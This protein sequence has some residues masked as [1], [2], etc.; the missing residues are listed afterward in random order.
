M[1]SIVVRHLD[2]HKI[3]HSSLEIL[4]HTNYEPLL[5]FLLAVMQ[6]PQAGCPGNKKS[7][8]WWKI[9]WNRS[10][11]E[12]VLEY[13]HIWQC[14]GIYPYFCWN[15]SIYENVLEYVHIWWHSKKWIKQLFSPPNI[16]L[17]LDYSCGSDRKQGCGWIRLQ[18]WMNRKEVSGSTN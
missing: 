2:S 3:I 5:L 9:W 11:F 13:I 4:K 17:C 18:N 1:H 16:W 10:I 6:P 8:I 14:D 15:M 12:N 7:I